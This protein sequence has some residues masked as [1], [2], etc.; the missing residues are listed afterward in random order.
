MDKFDFYTVQFYSDGFGN[1]TVV[2]SV[3]KTEE[4]ARKQAE[5]LKNRGCR[6]PDVIGGSFGEELYLAFND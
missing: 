5:E 1:D 4:E 3:W 6:Y 2:D